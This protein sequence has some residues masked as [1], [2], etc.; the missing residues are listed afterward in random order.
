MVQTKSF[1]LWKFVRSSTDMLV[2]DRKISLDFLL[3]FHLIFRLQVEWSTGT[4]S[5]GSTEALV[6]LVIQTEAPVGIEYWT[7][8]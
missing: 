3:F 8:D 5:L 7:N 2:G 4:S 1:A 6:T